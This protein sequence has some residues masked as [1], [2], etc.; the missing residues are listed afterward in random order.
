VFDFMAGATGLEPATSSVTGGRETSNFNDSF[1]SCATE[2]GSKPPVFDSGGRGVES[3]N[4]PPRP[5]W[6]VRLRRSIFG[7]RPCRHCG[8]TERRYVRTVMGS[9]AVCGYCWRRP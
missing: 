7:P 6:W 3:E 2:S 5:P 4:P 9:V 1:D 8:G